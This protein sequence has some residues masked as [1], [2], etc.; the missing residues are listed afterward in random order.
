[1]TWGILKGNDQLTDEQF[2]NNRNLHFRSHIVEISGIYEFYFNQEQ[3]G[4]RYNIKGARGMRAKNITYYSF[5]GFGAFYF[6]PQA[7]HNGSWVSLQPLGTEGQGLPGGKR[8]YSRVNVAIPMGLGA[9]Y[10]ID[11]Y[12]KIGL[13]VGY[14]KT[15][16]DYIDDVSSDYYDNAAIRAHKGET[17]A[18]LADPNLGHFNYQLDENG[19]SRHGIQRGNPKNMDAY[20]FGMI[21]LN[22]TIQKRS[23][24][25]KF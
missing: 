4:H 5:I 24:R 21:N 10:A 13:E 9:R 3:T 23:S 15:F 11:R 12:W 20:I 14:R 25:A 7:V 8:K 18:A 19:K 22:Y 17:A 16:T 6:N 1:I 2:R